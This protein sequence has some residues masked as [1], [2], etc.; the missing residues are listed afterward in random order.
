MGTEFGGRTTTLMFEDYELAPFS[1]LIRQRCP[2]SPILL[3]N[4][5]AKLVRASK[6]NGKEMTT[7]VDDVFSITIADDTESATKTN[8]N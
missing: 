8:R 6:E 2:L 4:Y 5:T 3:S 1:I 7:F